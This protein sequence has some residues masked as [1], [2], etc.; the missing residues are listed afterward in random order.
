[1]N[2]RLRSVA[3]LLFIRIYQDARWSTGDYN[4]IYMMNQYKSL[5]AC[6]E[7]VCVCVRHS[8]DSRSIYIYTY[9]YIYI[10]IIIQ[11][12]SLKALYFLFLLPYGLYGL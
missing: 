2:C 8:F 1:M 4:M 12:I 10:V 9:I 11:H 5:P 3:V 6:C 7:S